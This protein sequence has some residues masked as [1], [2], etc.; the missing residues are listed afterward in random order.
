MRPSSLIFRKLLGERGSEGAEPSDDAWLNRW[1]CLVVL[2]RL[3]SSLP[4]LFTRSIP[5]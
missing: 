4:F 1:Q 5:D 2:E 3:F